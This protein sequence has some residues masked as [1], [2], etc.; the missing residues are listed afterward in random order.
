MYHNSFLVLKVF[1]WT[2][3]DNICQWREIHSLS[4]II[5]NTCLTSFGDVSAVFNGHDRT[6]HQGDLVQT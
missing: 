2:G 5:Y 1:V 6:N 3:E 4:Y